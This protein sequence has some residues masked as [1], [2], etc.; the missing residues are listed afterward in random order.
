M[1]SITDQ[2]DEVANQE[3][4]VLIIFCSFAKNSNAKLF[5]CPTNSPVY[6][7]QAKSSGPEAAQTK[8]KYNFHF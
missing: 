7:P 3:T 8:A 1:V 5:W 2:R 4:E 6:Q